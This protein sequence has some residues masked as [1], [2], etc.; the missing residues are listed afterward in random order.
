MGHRLSKPKH[1]ESHRKSKKGPTGKTQPPPPQPN[2]QQPP[3]PQQQPPPPQQR[4]LP[5][6]QQPAAV[7]AEPKPLPEEEAKPAVMEEEEGQ[8]G[9]EDGVGNDESLES[10]FHLWADRIFSFDYTDYHSRCLA[11]SN[12]NDT[13]TIS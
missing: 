2:Q 9:Q 8:L 1:P 12:D 10:W 5:P 3:P 11:Q 7:T 6:E 4:S 13:D